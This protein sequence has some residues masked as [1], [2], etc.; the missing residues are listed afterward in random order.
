MILPH[1]LLEFNLVEKSDRKQIEEALKLYQAALKLHSQELYEEAALAYDNLFASEI[2]TYPESLPQVERLGLYDE[3]EIHEG[4]PSL[5]PRANVSIENGGID[6][7]PSTLAQILYL[8]YK[9]HG[10]FLLDLLTNQVQ[11]DSRDIEWRE[12]ASSTILSSLRRLVEALDRDDTDLGL[13]RQVARI[14]ESLGSTRVARYCLEAVLAADRDGTD[15]WPELLSLD[16]IFAVEQL[17]ALLRALGDNSKDSKMTIPPASK[18]CISGP[19]KKYID[20][21]PHLPQMP[22]TVFEHQSHREQSTSLIKVEMRGWNSCGKAIMLQICQE[23]PSLVGTTPEV[24]YSLQFPNQ[25]NSSTQQNAGVSEEKEPSLVLKSVDD[26]LRLVTDGHL[27]TVSRANSVL[28][29]KAGKEPTAYVHTIDS[30]D[31]S[32][33]NEAAV[34]NASSLVKDPGPDNFTQA[35][36]Q[37]LREGESTCKDNQTDQFHTA[38]QVEEQPGNFVTT[39]NLPAVVSLPTRKRSTDS[40]GLQENVDTGRVRSKRIKARGSMNES[41]T[42]KEVSPEELNQ[43]YDDQFRPTDEADSLLSDAARAILSKL[44]VEY[45]EFFGASQEARSPILSR[46][47]L[48]ESSSKL[49][50]S[51]VAAQDFLGLLSTWDKESTAAFLYGDGLDGKLGGSNNLSGPRNSGLNLFLEHSKRGSEFGSQ[52]PLF[53]DDEDL[54]AFATEIEESWTYLDQLAL[55][56]IEALLAPRRTDRGAVFNSRYEDYVW[57]ETLKRTVVLLLVMRDE[58]IYSEMYS[59]LKRLD[60]RILET[61]ACD[62]FDELQTSEEDLIQTVQNIFELHLDTYGKAIGPSSEVDPPTRILQLDRL[63]RWAMLAHDAISKKASSD[64]SDCILDS[65]DIRFLWASVLHTSLIDPMSRE[66]TIL[67]FEDLK[68]TL[69]ETGSPAIELANNCMMPDISSE[70]AER[71]I[72]RVTT[73]DFFLNLFNNQESNPLMIIEGLEP[74]LEQSVQIQGAV[75]TESTKGD[76]LVLVIDEEE[77]RTSSPERLPDVSSKEYLSQ[78]QKQMLQFVDQASISLKDILWEKLGEAYVAIAYPPKALS[79]ALR[80]IEIIAGYLG[81][82]A[83]VTK[84]T[85]DRYSGLLRWLRV[86]GDLI[87]KALTLILNETGIIHLIDTPH[88]CSAI[89]AILYF[90]RILYVQLFWEDSIRIGKIPP[91]KV[92]CAHEDVQ[93][94]F[95]K[96]RDMLVRIWI[97]QYSL[98]KEAY[99]QNPH[100]STEPEQD[101]LEYLN[102]LHHALGLRGFCK[103]SD[104]LFPIFMKKELMQLKGPESSDISMVQLIYD[105]YG[106]KV[107]LNPAYLEDHGCPAAPLECETAIQIIDLVMNQARKMNIKDISK[108]ELKLVIDKMQQAIASPKNTT[109]IVLNRRIISAFLKSPINPVDLYR[110]L[111]GIGSLNGAA[112]SNFSTIDYSIVGD[113]GWYLLIGHIALAK[114]R[115]QK[116]LFPGSFDDLEIANTFFR[117]DLELGLEKWETWYRLA[118]VFDAMIEEA[119]TWTAEKLNSKMSELASL[120]RNAIHCYTMAVAAAIRI[121]DASCESADKIC[122]LYADF[123]CRIYASSRE[124]FSM[125]AFALQDF[126]KPYNGETRGMYKGHPFRTMTVYSAWKFA[127][128]L[129]QRALGHKSG[130]WM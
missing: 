20:P 85:S 51:N 125:E 122:E 32:R 77:K 69:T 3:T 98:F 126:T 54:E 61:T 118:Q 119:T 92:N 128:V 14:C 33:N 12:G 86:V 75:S 95:N 84:S 25:H 114:F 48:I 101:F 121:E 94:V 80:R 70:A 50:S 41:N 106:L 27:N 78:D 59:R 107:C 45:P 76:E 4:V 103:V 64:K 39:P 108:S 62:K 120:Q 90:Q 34:S 65:L 19:L 9:N 30:D 23:G 89:K 93:S 57:P 66:H 116:R 56:W 123:A 10:Q 113:K 105:L 55:K 71:E 2:F 97:I 22:P 102:S 130:S 87:T 58:Y 35:A 74:I 46:G 1:E 42:F 29:E 18:K 110:S 40:A 124:P 96:L 129:F 104:R 100:L 67:C 11:K 21:C 38:S 117:L 115:S 72:S 91:P 83:F 99:E 81:S 52:K 8:S 31:E 53:P 24:R 49:V 79:C 109:T 82:D 13:W 6:G 111:R 47:S 73:M 68:R 36:Q 88:L 44:E 7:A 15:H 43:F 17:T 37:N 5:S 16:R 26:A 127:S 60:T 63:G 28:D 112:A